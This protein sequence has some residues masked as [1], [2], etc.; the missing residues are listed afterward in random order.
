VENARDLV[1][2]GE[3]AEQTRTAATAIRYYEKLGLMSPDERRGGRRR[4]SEAAAERVAFSRLYQDVGFT[5]REIGEILDVHDRSERPWPR[6]AERK[7][8]EL[9]LRI[10]TAAK[11]KNLL[12]HAVNCPHP[13]L[14]ACPNF[15][16]ELQARLAP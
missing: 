7:I 1:E 11:A 6:L 12:E 16:R 3:L 9:D 4:Y 2:I 10:S 8:R 13:N 15:R 14:L 5:L